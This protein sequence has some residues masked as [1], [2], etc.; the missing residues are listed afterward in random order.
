MTSDFSWFS[1]EL[2][3]SRETLARLKTYSEL[4][5][6]WNARIN[7]VAPSTVNDLWR[8]HFRDSAQLWTLK[9]AVATTWLDLG[10]GAGFPGM[11][12]A[13]V[14]AEK[15][16]ELTVTL[17]ESDLRKATFLRTVAQALSIRPR[18]HAVRIED[19]PP[20]TSDVVSARALA[21]LTKL[22]AMA[23]S[24]FGPETVGL[25]P[26]GAIAEVE[27]EEALAFWRFS[28]QKVRSQTDPRATILRIGELSHA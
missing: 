8:R 1:D 18:I 17:V 15:A 10:S 13:V 9:P 16:P 4:L 19:L 27:V 12:I 5:I 20:S 11:I 26:K 23:K 14:A 25:F 28:V 22:L 7:L 3:V 6:K 21:P 24:H 2:A